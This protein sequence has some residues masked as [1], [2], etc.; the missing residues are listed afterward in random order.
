MIAGT[1]ATL[2]RDLAQGRIR[3]VDLTQTLAP[4]FPQIVLA[5]DLGQAAPFRIEEVS[6]YDERGPG[7]YWNNFTC[8][9]H[10]GTHFDA[11]IHWI[12][13]RHLPNNATDT[14]AVADLIGP[15]CVI[16][17]SQEAAQDADFLLTANHIRQW[18]AAHGRIPERAWVLMRTDWSKRHDPVAY[19]NFDE[20]GQHTPGPATDAV[21][22]LV[23]ERNAI[24]F[25]SEAI[26]TDAGQ[27]F[28]LKPPYPCHYFMHG[29]GR[30]GLQC[31][32]N[33]DLLPPTG[34][35]II[36]PPLK[37]KQ[38]SGSPL[39]VLALVEEHG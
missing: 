1:L 3:V 2:V 36:C 23:E 27:G 37:I 33:L 6:R 13:G 38:G 29:N 17:C 7:W 5:P 28:H 14:L 12:S 26:G 22:M 24:G 16:D 35:V 4:E 11:P 8:S 19:Q 18:E 34:A 39:R 30:H 31:L 20:E 9:E 10:T 25:G 15:A 32:T 21:R